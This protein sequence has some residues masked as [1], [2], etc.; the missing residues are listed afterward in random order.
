MAGSRG[1]RGYESSGRRGYESRLEAGGSKLERH[2]RGYV[3]TRV[4]K[5]E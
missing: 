1:R 4:D 3:F 2:T 5:W